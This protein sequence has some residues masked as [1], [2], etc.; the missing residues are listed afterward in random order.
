MH[1]ASLR[2]AGSLGTLAGVVSQ[3]RGKDVCIH[4][5]AGH[6]HR[7]TTPDIARALLQRRCRC[8]RASPFTGI[9]GALEQQAHG[10]RDFGYAV[11]GKVSSGMDVVDAIAAV[12]TGT[13]AGHQDVPTE[14]VEIIE[15]TID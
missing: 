7:D 8:S 10:G 6:H 12:D 2:P 4:V 1:G 3:H 15:V 13:H 14:T 9:V 5:A 11:F